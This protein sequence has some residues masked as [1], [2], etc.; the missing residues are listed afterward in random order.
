MRCS[1]LKPC[2]TPSRPAARP[3]SPAASPRSCT[4]ARRARSRASCASA[5]APARARRALA[6][7]RPLTP[8]LALRGCRARKGHAFHDPPSRALVLVASGI[9]L[10]LVTARALRKGITPRQ[11]ARTAVL[12]GAE[13]WGFGMLFRLQEFLLGRPYAPW[14]DLLRVDILNIIGVA[15]ILMGLV[16]WLAAPRIPNAPATADP[17]PR[18][19][20]PRNPI[21]RTAPS[22]PIPLAPPPLSPP[23]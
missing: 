19:P 8:P 15:I 7:P 18:G 13:I 6:R 16:C 3:S 23:N 4:P 2:G 9:S 12:R 11:A 14:T 20:P 5:P 10:W 22:P 17:P 21:A 1:W